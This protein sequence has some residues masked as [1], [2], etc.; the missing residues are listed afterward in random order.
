MCS[1]VSWTSGFLSVRMGRFRGFSVL[2][3]FSW[4]LDFLDFLSDFGIFIIF[5]WND[6]QESSGSS[7]M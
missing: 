6:C 2:W 4:C 3:G 1:K 5:L 7:K